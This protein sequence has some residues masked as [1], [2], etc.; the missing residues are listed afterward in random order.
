MSE[1]AVLDVLAEGELVR[2]E[3]LRSATG[4]SREVLRTL[5]QKKWIVREDLSGVRDARR[6][7]KIAVLR[8][9]LSEVQDAALHE[10][11]AQK[12]N[13]AQQRIVD[14]L[15]EAQG[16]M[17]MDDLREAGT[18]PSS[19][20]TLVK[21]DW[22]RSSRSQPSGRAADEAAHHARVSV[23]SRPEEALRE[24][25][26]SVEARRFQGCVAARR[27]RLGKNGGVSGGHAVGAGGGAGLDSAGAGDWADS[28]RGRRPAQHLRR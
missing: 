18:S 1:Y 19:L 16:R 6:L 5:L 27:H 21:H 15:R 10:V 23:H 13:A 28:G 14:L 25:R 11:Q 9:A 26:G 22:W 4:A 7:V 17:R 2:E 20:K 8:E 24:I 3:R 12:L